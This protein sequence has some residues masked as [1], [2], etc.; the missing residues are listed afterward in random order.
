MKTLIHV[1]ESAKWELALQ[2]ARN[3]LNYGAQVGMEFEIEIVANGEAVR[4]LKEE[5]AR[6]DG[7]YDTIRDLALD[8]VRFAACRNALG[9]YEIR[10]SSLIPFV[11]V[12]AAGLVELVKKQH[13]GYAYIK[14]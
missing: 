8:G 10:E 6:A 4:E 3:M 13:D 5:T 2:N 11:E 12:V 14:P 1:D 9:G 7:R